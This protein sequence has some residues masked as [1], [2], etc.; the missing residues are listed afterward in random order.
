MDKDAINA[1]RAAV[2]GDVAAE[3]RQAQSALRESQQR[4][5]AALTAAGTGTFRWDLA[6]NT[7]DAD[8]NLERIF[9]W[10]STGGTRPIQEFIDVVHP[11]DRAV[12]ILEI[13]KSKT[14][15][16]GAKIAF[17]VEWPNGSVRW[18]DA[19][20]TMALDAAGNPDYMIGACH[21]ITARKN[22]EHE[23][24]DSAQ[25]FE[26]V[27]N[28]AAVGIA[29]ANLDGRL[30][31]VNHKFAEI[32]AYSASEL[33]QRT[34]TDFTHPDDIARTYE[35]MRALVEL[36]LPEYVYEKRYLRK[37]G[38]LVWSRTR[39]AFLRNAF[40]VA[41]QFIGVIEDITERKVADAALSALTDRVQAAS[42][43]RE[44][45]L[46]SERH[47][48]TQAE[49]MSAMKDEFLATLSHELRTPLSA[50]LG[51]SQLLRHA[52]LE[53]EEHVKGL[54]TIE[55]NA[56]I[57]QQLIEDLLDM[58]RITS[59]NLRLNIQPVQPVAFVEAALETILHAAN[60][61]GIQ[62]VRNFEDSAG[63]IYGD[64]HRL[65]QVVW[66]LLSNAIKFTPRRGR[67][68]IVLQRVDSHIRIAVAD[69]GIGIQPEFIAQVFERFRQADSSTTR[70]QGGLG[71][72]LS[73]VR[74]LVELHGGSASISSAGE[75]KGTTVTLLLPVQAARPT[76]DDDGTHPATHAKMPFDFRST[77]LKGVSVLVVDDHADAREL[78]ERVLL[79][80]GATVY[81][82]GNADDAVQLVEQH[83]PQV[84]I[85][86]IGMPDA[87][88]Y[89]LIRR[90]R[91]LGAERGGALPAIALT[92]FARSD[93]R[94]RALRAGFLVHVSKPVEAAE[95]VAT[96]ASVVGRTDH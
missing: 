23:L 93:D 3:L 37:D 94:T 82:A 15:S 64:A 96:V 19:Q 20:A 28:Q 62:I 69:S 30:V 63:P 61:K 60:A 46:I 47:A 25:R 55:R 35:S 21:D 33:E 7:I 75:G 92:A 48:R 27:F 32:L 88:G 80:C 10:K 11:D 72:G 85:S 40:G 16:A 18:V 38:S 31:K 54:D 29:V 86:D 83:K 91:A 65:Q 8:F 14:Q 81:T 45:L 13:E 41:T 50:I 76:T 73:I 84:M 57:Q 22:V 70:R 58:S 95:L 26:A 56:R 78:V 17:R 42:E 4:L 36:Q 44:K 89:E 66:N 71:L 34:F 6:D 87:D 5:Q 74:H 49:H 67:V 79:A 24:Q 90:I 52:P 9:G 53:Q 39:V 68:E 1:P 77:D 2:E 43:E 51:W 59:G 12:V